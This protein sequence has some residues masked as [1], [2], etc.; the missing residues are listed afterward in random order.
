MNKREHEAATCDCL[1]IT[2]FFLLEEESVNLMLSKQQ[3]LHAEEIQH[4]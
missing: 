1:P 2:F 3:A 4:K